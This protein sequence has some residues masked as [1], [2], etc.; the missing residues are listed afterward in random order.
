ME[1]WKYDFKMKRNTIFPIHPTKNN[2]KI[3][4][5]VI[6]STL[7][8]R[9]HELTF[10][11]SFVWLFLTLWFHLPR[12]KRVVWN[13]WY[14]VCSKGLFYIISNTT[15]AVQTTIREQKKTENLWMAI[16]GGVWTVIWNFWKSFLSYWKFIVRYLK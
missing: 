1:K 10:R 4:T 6:P 9:K 5:E 3:R 13:L 11:Y 16:H 2:R 15:T 12:M 8:F 14:G 7:Y